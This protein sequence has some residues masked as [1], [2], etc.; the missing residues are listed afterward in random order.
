M[1][2]QLHVFVAVEQQQ[3]AR[4]TAVLDGA[5]GIDDVTLLVIAAHRE[6]NGGC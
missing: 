5:P 6:S 2:Q 1:E 3:V 4:S